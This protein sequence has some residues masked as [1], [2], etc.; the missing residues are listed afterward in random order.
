MGLTVI[1]V[2]QLLHLFSLWISFINKINGILSCSAAISSS[3][4]EE[5]HRL[6]QKN[7]RLRIQLHKQ[8]INSIQVPAWQQLRNIVHLSYHKHDRFHCDFSFSIIGNIYVVP[9]SFLFQS[10]PLWE[11]NTPTQ[12]LGPLHS[13]PLELLVARAKYL[14]LGTDI[15]KASWPSWETGDASDFR[16][17]SDKQKGSTSFTPSSSPQS[18]V[19]ASEDDISG[20]EVEL[21]I[22][23]IGKWDLDRRPSASLF[24]QRWEGGRVESRKRKEIKQ[25]NL[26]HPP[27]QAVS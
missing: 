8:N 11:A 5:L 3:H 2:S 22:E 19:V 15:K 1:P 17:V 21:S 6:G 12:N 23:S 26:R 10:L 7:K 20:W 9:G 24:I 16:Q 4:E 27:V 13:L 14:V 25:L 18:W